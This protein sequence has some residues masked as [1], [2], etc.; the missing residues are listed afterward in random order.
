ML[1]YIKSPRPSASKKTMVCTKW[2]WR[3]K[4]WSSPMQQNVFS[5]GL[6]WNHNRHR[7]H[8]H[9]GQLWLL[10]V[11]GTNVS[12]LLLCSQVVLVLCLHQIHVIHPI[13]TYLLRMGFTTHGNIRDEGHPWRGSMWYDWNHAAYAVCMDANFGVD[14]FEMFW[15]SPPFSFC[16]LA[17]KWEHTRHFPCRKS[18]N[19]GFQSDLTRADCEQRNVKHHCHKTF[20]HTPKWDDFRLLTTGISKLRRF[21]P[22]SFRAKV[23][24]GGFVEKRDLQNT[25]SSKRV[26]PSVLQNES[27]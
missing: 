26:P 14:S 19:G 6:S 23:G 12:G 15:T 10:F 11:F 17:Q 8:I 7:R 1:W 13:I 25:G 3:P 20:R 22:C 27:L 16:W 4:C 21:S 9:L 5:F 18:T 2:Q 24:A